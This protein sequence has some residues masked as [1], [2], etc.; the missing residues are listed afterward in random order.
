M[1]KIKLLGEGKEGL[2]PGGAQPLAALPGQRACR[3]SPDHVCVANRVRRDEL[4][5]L[6]FLDSLA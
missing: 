3:V 4:V 2:K 1:P 6:G 5:T